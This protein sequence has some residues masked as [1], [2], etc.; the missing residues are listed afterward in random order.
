MNQC[1][2]KDIQKN[3]I[4]SYKGKINTY[5]QENRPRKEGSHCVF[6]SVITTDSVF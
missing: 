1:T 3:K 6:L 2:I 5:Y 4:K